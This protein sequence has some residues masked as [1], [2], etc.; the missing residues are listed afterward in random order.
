MY[1]YEQSADF[2]FYS[3]SLVDM[4]ADEGDI[5]RLA[6]VAETSVEYECILVKRGTALH[7]R[8]LIY[9]TEPVPNSARRF[10]YT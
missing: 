5:I 3:P 10:G 2:R 7:R 6:R 9:C 1:E 4:D 8:W